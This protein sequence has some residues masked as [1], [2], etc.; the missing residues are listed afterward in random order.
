MKLGAYAAALG[1]I[2]QQ[3]RLDVIA[4][5]IANANTPG[6]KKDNVHFS[7]F[8]DEVTYTSM[9]QGP[10]QETG[11]KLDIALNGTGLLKVQKDQ[12]TFYTRAGNLTLN[13]DKILVNQDGLPVLGKRGPIKLDYP[14]NLRIEENGQVFDGN[15]QVDTLDVVQFSSDVTLRKTQNGYFE[16]STKDAQ[17]IQAKDCTVRQGALEGANFNPVEEMV[18]MVETTRNFEAYQ[19]TMTTFDR[20]LDGQLITRLT[21]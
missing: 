17:P 3:K 20:D 10:I 4:N 16:P 6:F 1:S 2:E 14:G 9:D 5:N 13:S 12:E 18:R 15:N 7:N 8:M 19:K 11:H 21:T